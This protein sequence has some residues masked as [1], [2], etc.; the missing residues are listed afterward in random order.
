[1]TI[2]KWDD[3]QLQFDL[4]LNEEADDAV[5]RSITAEEARRISEAA[6]NGFQARVAQIDEDERP[7]WFEDYVRLLEQGWPWRVACYIA[8]A[9]SPKQGRWPGT[10]RE[11]ATDVLGLTGPRVIYTWRRKYPTIDQVVAVVQ[12][13]PLFEHR[14][15][16]MNALVMSAR[17]PDYKSF[18]DRKLFLE[19]TGDYTPKSKVEV[20]RSGRAGD[21]SEKSDDELRAWL[22]MDGERIER[23]GTDGEGEDA[24]AAAE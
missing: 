17:D 11:L 9:G 3:V 20:E 5:E 4:D 23:M 8:W 7:T 19:M 10:L 16:V 21:I 2:R 24:S 14:R 15:D 1:M 22:G 6:Y 12:A 13:A 18:N